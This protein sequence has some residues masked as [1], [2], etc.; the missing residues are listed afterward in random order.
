MVSFPFSSSIIVL[1]A[2]FK[3]GAGK[4]ERARQRAICFDSICPN[5]SSDASAA[6]AKAGEQIDFLRDFRPTG[7][8]GNRAERR[9]ANEMHD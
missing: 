1:A 4:N 3:L 6:E 8:C 5:S 2:N 9:G 7:C